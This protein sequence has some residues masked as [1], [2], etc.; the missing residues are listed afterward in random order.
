MAEKKSP[1]LKRSLSLTLVVLYGLGA[2][3]GAGIYVLIGVTAQHAGV[4]AP[5]SFLIAALVM[6]PTAASF[7]ELSVRMPY[8]AGEAAYVMRGFGSRTL[9]LVVGLMVVTAGMVSAAAVTIGGAGYLRAFVD[10]PEPVIV[11][12]IVAF[13]G[14][15]VAWGIT[16]SVAFAG[17]LTAIEIA[18]LLVIGVFGFGGD[19]NLFFRLPEV[20][21]STF[22][23]TI[24]TGILSAGL[25]AF[26]AFVG[27]E[28]IVN[29]VEETKRPE[30]TMPWGIGLTLIISVMLYFVVAS[31]AV[32]SVPIP[33]LAASKSPLSDVFE[34]VT[35]AS[36]R[37]M[38]AIAVIATLN[39]MIIQMIM[40]SR[41]L[42]GLARQDQL[43]AAIGRINPVTRTPLMATG[44][45]VLIVYVLAMLFPIERL[46]E[47]TA[48]VTLCIFTIV[49]VALIRI[50]LNGPDSEADMPS[51]EV[52]IYVPVIGVLFSVGL[53]LTGLL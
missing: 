46:A 43:P 25:L 19:P 50:K 32:L 13:M 34:T 7:S 18:G 53:L 12:V 37:Y 26:F 27:F 6:A 24:W 44:L 8:T 23:I 11:T 14:L 10:L 30:F 38:S 45:V 28:D 15:V 20:V 48:Q 21:P 17:T 49:N 31:V 39:G 42:Y 36:A 52:P 5:F 3:V 4:Y 16:Q 29:I 1:E 35:G 40:A 33:E 2:T 22:D 41:V 9:S 47:W 51:F